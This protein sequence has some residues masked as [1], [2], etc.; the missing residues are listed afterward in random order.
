MLE[1]NFQKKLVKTLKEH[2]CYVQKY[3]ASPFS[4]AGV[5]D[6]Y[7]FF[8][9]G[10]YFALEV[11]VPPNKASPLQELHIETIKKQGGFAMVITPNLV[12]KLLELI[13]ENSQKGD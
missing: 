10:K 3:A 1:S 11:K 13:A 9:N 7:G 6:L 2:H 4:K 8:P 5:P 12:P